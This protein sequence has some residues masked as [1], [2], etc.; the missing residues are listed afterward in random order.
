VVLFDAAS[1]ERRLE[2]KHT[3]SAATWSGSMSL[4]EGVPLVADG[5]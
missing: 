3:S 1:E 4:Q 5:S 2:P